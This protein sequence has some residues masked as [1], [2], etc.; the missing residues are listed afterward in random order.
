M[1]KWILILLLGIFLIP[2]VA[3][4][5]GEVSLSDIQIDLWP[6]YD[7][8]SMLVI[9]RMT[10]SAETTL[11]AQMMFRI[12]TSAGKPNVVAVGQSK[13]TVDEV[14]YDYQVVGSM[15]EVSFTAALPVIQVEYYDPGIERDGVTRKFTYGWLGEYTVNSVIVSVQ[16]PFGA[17]GMRISPGS[18]NP[19]TG[20]EGLVYYTIEA[21]MVKQGQSFTVSL[22]YQ[23]SSESLTAEF[24]TVQPS[25]P[26]PAPSPNP[27]ISQAL[28]W[29]LG[30]VGV[31]LIIG[32]VSWYFFT[33]RQKTRVISLPRGRRKSARPMVK[34]S[35]NENVY[36]H[37]CGTRASTGDRFCRS[38][39]AELRVE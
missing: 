36:C 14:A 39:G 38:C 12:P 27:N 32:G 25:E 4:S 13:S 35:V 29:L 37:Q 26:L 5:Q 33:G 1:R 8:A 17:T 9:Y 15:A 22:E 24:L 6:E 11:P 31:T 28:P 16:Q 23:K 2:G 10:L 7:R 19:L 30:G 18:M 20:A 34:E 21:G 3:R